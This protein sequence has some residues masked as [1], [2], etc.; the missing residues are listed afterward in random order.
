MHR[1]LSRYFSYLIRIWEAH[2]DDE[3]TLRASLERP[4]FKERVGFS[5]MDELFEFIREDVRK[6]TS[7]DVNEA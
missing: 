6:T 2:T 7:E 1:E 4:G 3:V 5:N